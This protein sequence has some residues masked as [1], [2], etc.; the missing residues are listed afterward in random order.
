MRNDAPISDEAYEELE[1]YIREPQCVPERS[2]LQRLARWIAD[3]RS[4]RP[5]P[6]PSPNH[7]RASTCTDRAARVRPTLASSV[8]VLQVSTPVT[9]TEGVG[10][11]GTPTAGRV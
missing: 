9:P 8:G 5:T 2:L 1:P 3:A 4:A 11:E 6:T 7:A 10:S